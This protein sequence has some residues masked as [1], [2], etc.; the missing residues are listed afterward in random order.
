ME[1]TLIDT[2]DIK[3]GQMI[4]FENPNAMQGDTVAAEYIAAYDQQYWTSGGKHY[5]I[6][7]PLPTD[8]G[9]IIRFPRLVPLVLADGERW[10]FIQPVPQKATGGLT[11]EQVRSR[12]NGDDFTL[13]Y[14][15]GEDD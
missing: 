10:Y 4:R 12:T 14:T 15:P 8:Y 2:A 13:V 9:T 3:K 1:K 6:L 11:P 5:S 7:K